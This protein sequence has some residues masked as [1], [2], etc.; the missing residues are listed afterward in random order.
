MGPDDGWTPSSPR[1]T[2]E[3]PSG[4]GLCTAV[5]ETCLLPLDS[6]PPSVFP[7]HQPLE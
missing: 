6:R 2:W 7:G 5:L 1:L 3:A 4:H